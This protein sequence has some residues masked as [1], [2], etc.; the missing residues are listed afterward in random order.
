MILNENK[1]I[2]HA[3]AGH[4]VAAH[5]AGCRF[6][7]TLYMKELSQGADIILVSPGGAPK[8]MNLYQTQKALD[9][10]RHAVKPGGIII[11]IGACQEG[12]GEWVFEEWMTA[13]PSP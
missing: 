2:V 11:L 3:V 12:M 8:D 9:N 10:A 5:R 7:D 4:S 1:E 6:L 13:S